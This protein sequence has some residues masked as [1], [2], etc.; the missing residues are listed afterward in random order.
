MFE[1]RGDAQVADE[2]L[3]D[4]INCELAWSRSSIGTPK[5]RW[6]M[7]RPA[8]AAAKTKPT[9]TPAPRK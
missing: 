6:P 2:E 5:R 8:R 9:G 7:R 3:F 1:S 4:A